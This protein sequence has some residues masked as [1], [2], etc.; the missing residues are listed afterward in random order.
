MINY[1]VAAYLLAAFNASALWWG[2][3]LV[4]AVLDVV[5]QLLRAT[6]M[7]LRVRRTS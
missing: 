6:G 7:R 3:L 4:V 2:G 1:F 5:V